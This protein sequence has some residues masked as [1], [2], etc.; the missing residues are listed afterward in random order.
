MFISHWPG[1]NSRTRENCLQAFID[2]IRVIAWIH[3]LTFLK[4]KNYLDQI[5]IEASST[6]QS[7]VRWI[8]TKTIW[9]EQTDAT[10]ISIQLKSKLFFADL[11]GKPRFRFQSIIVILKLS[12]H[13]EFY[14][15]SCFSA[16]SVF[17]CL[18][19]KMRITKSFHDN[20]GWCLCV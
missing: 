20:F 2:K 8:W 6:H 14:Q 4:D 15:F 17:R 9:T 1:R 18:W 19:T 5:S 13:A 7:S 12:L 11:F 10:N 3:S 16:I